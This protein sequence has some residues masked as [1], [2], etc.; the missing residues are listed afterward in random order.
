MY[1]AQIIH[2]TVFY[3]SIVLRRSYLVHFFVFYLPWF[4]STSSFFRF[5]W[6]RFKI[7]IFLRDEN[8]IEAT[9]F[10]AIVAATSSFSRCWSVHTKC[11]KKFYLLK[12]ADRCSKSDIK[13][14]MTL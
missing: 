4:N 11:R 8:E 3:I 7:E 1:P 6:L 9:V 13:N 5:L 14:L 12:A 10:L 2:G